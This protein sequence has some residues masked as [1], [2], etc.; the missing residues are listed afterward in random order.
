MSALTRLDSRIAIQILAI[1]D[2]VQRFSIDLNGPTYPYF[3]AG[4]MAL[5]NLVV[6]IGM[7]IVSIGDIS[8]SVNFAWKVCAIIV[9]SLAWAIK[10]SYIKF[11]AES[12]VQILLYCLPCKRK[13]F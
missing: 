7:A 6:W 1:D 4:I 9:V 5:F 3:V 2:D 10:Q 12:S 8:E 11:M 13:G